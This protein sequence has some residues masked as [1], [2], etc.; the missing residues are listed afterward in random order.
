MEFNFCLSAALC[1]ILGYREFFT[2]DWLEPILSWQDEVF[3]C[4]RGELVF[5]S[6]VSKF[7]Y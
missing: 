5:E 3:G 7:L 2:S 6:E 1:G 4:Y